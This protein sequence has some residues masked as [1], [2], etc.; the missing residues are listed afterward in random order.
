LIHQT[1]LLR[2][3]R[4][5]IRA[6]SDPVRQALF[7]NLKESHLLVRL[8]FSIHERLRNTAA[9]ALLVSS[10][11]LGVFV[12][13]TAPRHDRASLLSVARHAN[14]R[15]QIAR[16]AGWLEP[17]ACEPLNARVV[18]LPRRVAESAIA[19]I[20]SNRSFVRAYR[21]VRRVDQRHGFLVACRVASAIAWYARGKT[22][23]R[24]RR[25]DAVVVSSDTNP[26]E[27]GFTAAARALGIPTVF[28]SHAY[29][30]PFSPP[31]AFNLSILGGQ[32]EVDARR[33]RGA[34]A[35]QILLAGLEGESTSLNTTQFERREPV[36]G[37]F[38]P[39]AVSWDTLATVIADCR[40]FFRARQIVIRWH[41]SMLEPP[42]L[43]HRLG[44]LSRIVESPKTA[45]LADVA[46]QCDWVIADENSSV[47]LPVLKLGIPSIAV[48]QL[49]RYPETRTDMYGLVRDRIVPPAVAS[50]RD[51][52]PDALAAFFS[53]GWAARFQ[54]YDASYARPQ[55]A[56]EVEVRA[57][58][59]QLRNRGALESTGG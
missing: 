46:R 9:S 32:A 21:V 59:Q 3:I 33:R 4:I 56:I 7:A 47:H 49:G 6:D 53:N 38:A 10:Y 26:E 16:I 23:L 29:P 24:T 15:R 20:T 35:G 42:R 57:A 1:C 31:L 51:V 5:V 50:I 39:K 11:G 30:T 52:R 13:L 2:A 37:I 34:I 54:Q 14:A 25:P 45:K 22:I 40:H 44:D 27:V 58:I 12:T 28:V 55:A 17:G 19:L 48:R 36:I 8:V 43:S 18:A 41:P